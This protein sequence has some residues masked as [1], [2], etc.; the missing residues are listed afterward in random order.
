MILRA[1]DHSNST[2]AKGLSAGS[3]WGAATGL[4]RRQDRAEGQ[5]IGQLPRIRMILADAP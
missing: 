3:F 4:E 2:A 1:E 5:V